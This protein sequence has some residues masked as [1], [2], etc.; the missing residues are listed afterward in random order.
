MNLEEILERAN[1]GDQQAL[2]MVLQMDPKMFELTK[3]DFG[4]SEND[5]TGLPREL[6]DPQLL[7]MY[8]GPGRGFADEMIS[9]GEIARAQLEDEKYDLPAS[10]SASG[11]YNVGS[12]ALDAATA[13][14]RGIASGY[15]AVA[16]SDSALS[17]FVPQSPLDAVLRG[18]AFTTLYDGFQEGKKILQEG[19]RNALFPKKPLTKAEKNRG[20]KKPYKTE[21]STEVKDQLERGPKSGNTRAYLPPSDEKPEGRFKKSPR[22]KFDKTLK[23]AGLSSVDEILGNSKYQGSFKQQLLQHVD[24]VKSKELK[25]WNR[26]TGSLTARLGKALSPAKIEDGKVKARVPSGNALKAT[27]IGAGA[28]GAASALYGIA[29]SYI[30]RDEFKEI[31][32]EEAKII[33]ELIPQADVL[34]LE[35]QI[36]S[37]DMYVRGC[38]LYTSDA[39]DE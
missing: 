9:E 23:K 11:F 19:R 15:S 10:P 26:V 36:E 13:I 3:E 1:N 2:Q 12:N 29:D 18:A 33:E 6:P 30:P 5:N 37:M 8:K 32:E 24:E 35:N 39:A 7:G 4:G 22:D 31:K 28:Y 14:P 17:Y 27:G 25:G 38:L 16:D 20:F 34:D 21:M